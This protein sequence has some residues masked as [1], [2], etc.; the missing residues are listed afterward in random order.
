MVCIPWERENF[1]DLRRQPGDTNGGAL[2][3]RAISLTDTPFSANTRA[4]RT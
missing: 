3:R 1:A 4:L 2:R